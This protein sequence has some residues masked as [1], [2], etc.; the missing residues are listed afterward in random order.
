M[1][2]AS[3]AFKRHTTLRAASA[4]I[5][6]IFSSLASA[7]AWTTSGVPTGV[8]VVRSE[9]LMVWGSFGNPNGCT[10]SNAFMVPISHPQYKE[11]Y[12]A[13]LF[14]MATGKPVIGYASVCAPATWYTVAS[15]TFNWMGSGDA[16][17]LTN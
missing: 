4:L 12:A 3:A 10:A 7:G 11:I 2:V 15:T 6:L 9:G 13:L 16:L 5:A 1:Q 8:D 17:N 14:S